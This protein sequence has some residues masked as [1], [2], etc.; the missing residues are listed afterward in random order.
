M[1]QVPSNFDQVVVVG[2]FCG[3]M[4]EDLFAYWTDPELV[5]QWWP[6][7]ASIDLQ[8]GGDYVFDWTETT[9]R[10]TYR[11]V[12]PGIQLSFTWQWDHALPGYDPLTVDLYFHSIDGGTRLA[13]FHGPF[14]PTEPDQ[15]SRAGIIEGWIHF[16]MRLA[17]LR[18]RTNP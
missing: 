14:E 17:G 5:T 12:R 8:E 4:P 1:I 10:G 11:V 6:S 7:Q 18:S 13:I 15:A 9:L 3:F 16:G 2:D